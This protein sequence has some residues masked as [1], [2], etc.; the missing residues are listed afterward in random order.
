MSEDE[1]KQLITSNAKAKYL[2]KIICIFFDKVGS[3]C[4]KRYSGVQTG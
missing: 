2:S 1:L 3:D 4:V